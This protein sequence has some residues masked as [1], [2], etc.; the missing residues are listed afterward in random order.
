MLP[1]YLDP[2]L[3]K[4]REPEG[5]DK[6]G[7]RYE[8]LLAWLQNQGSPQAG[9]YRN[10]SFLLMNSSGDLTVGEIYQGGFIVSDV[11]LA[12]W[13]METNNTLPNSSVHLT[14]SIGS[15]F[16]VLIFFA[17]CWRLCKMPW[18]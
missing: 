17:G 3:P 14:I 18:Q 4:F 15:V 10:M 11:I 2:D 13:P 6:D 5:L 16:W 7:E 12:R 1:C 8:F 9:R